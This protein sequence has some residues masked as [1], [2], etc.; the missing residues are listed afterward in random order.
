MRKTRIEK[1][2]WHAFGS[3]LVFG[4]IFQIAGAQYDTDALY[5]QSILCS[6][7]KEVR[8]YLRKHPDGAFVEAAIE[9]LEDI[10]IENF[11]SLCQAHVEAERLTSGASGN[12]LECYQSVL[13]RRP[14][15]VE[16][17][18]GLNQIEEIKASWAQEA[19]HD[20][21]LD[22]AVRYLEEL[23][24]LNP[25][26]SFLRELEAEIAAEILAAERRRSQ[27]PLGRFTD[28]E[29]CPVMVVVP[30]GSNF[31]GTQRSEKQS[32][33]ND[34]PRHQVDIEMPFAVSVYEVSRGEFARFISET[35]HSMGDSCMEGT[36][37]HWSERQG[38]GWRN[39]GYE[40]TDQHPVVCVSWKEA[41][42]YAAWLSNATEMEYRLLSESEWEYIA[43]AGSTA[44]YYYGNDFGSVISSKQVQQVQR[45]N[46]DSQNKRIVSSEFMDLCLHS[47]GAASETTFKSRN[48]KCSDGYTYTAP[49]GS[50]LSNGFGLHDVLGNVWEVVDDCWTAN[51][52]NAP[53]DGSPRLDGDCSKR[54]VRGGS[55]QNS[56]SWNSPALRHANNSAERYIN[57][58]FRIARNF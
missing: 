6:D 7:E 51:Y 43:R 39:P 47:N 53:T 32:S 24:T 36:D 21:N 56:P 45:R 40:Q 29:G 8:A 54:V 52:I 22:A 33:K 50:L 12:A 20:G 23:R 58:G 26:H 28:C 11:L 19:L 2:T 55:W 30:T 38:L 13:E 49:V 44:R 4:M 31:I 35:G 14:E 10:D 42:A 57:A 34:W 5:W 46:E 25:Q 16:A 41:K 9:C 15:N 3:I 18:K 27:N 1:F 48:K 37:N 17:Q